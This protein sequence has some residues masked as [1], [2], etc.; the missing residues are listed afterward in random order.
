MDEWKGLEESLL[1]AIFALLIT[2]CAP[3][4]QN[5]FLKIHVDLALILAHNGTL[6]GKI[7]NY[8]KFTM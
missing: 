5:E 2:G 6:D 7:A 1:F 8:W 4:T 3:G